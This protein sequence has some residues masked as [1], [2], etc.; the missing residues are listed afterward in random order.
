[1]ASTRE[2]NPFLSPIQD[3]RSI[4]TFYGSKSKRPSPIKV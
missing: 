4:H 3:T 1:M 2:E